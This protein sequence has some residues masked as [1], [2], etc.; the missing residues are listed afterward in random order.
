MADAEE[1][2]EGS[3]PAGEGRRLE[4]DEVLSGIKIKLSAEEQVNLPIN[5]LIT[6]TIAPKWKHPFISSSSDQATW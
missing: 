6:A 2:N 3:D 4:G 5:S 1:E